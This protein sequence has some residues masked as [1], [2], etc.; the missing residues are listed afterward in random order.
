MWDHA[1][2]PRM[3]QR[4]HRGV[5]ERTVNVRQTTSCGGGGR[6]IRRMVSPEHTLHDQVRNLRMTLSDPTIQVSDLAP[7]SRAS[8]NLVERDR[9]VKGCA[10][11]R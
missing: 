11:C 7:L 10:R 8:D 4:V 5:S 3:P 6:S 2:K 1:R 9:W